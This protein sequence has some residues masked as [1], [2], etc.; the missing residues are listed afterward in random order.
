MYIFILAMMADTL[1][2]SS[3]PEEIHRSAELKRA[4]LNVFTQRQKLYCTSLEEDERLLRTE[5]SVRERMAVEVRLGEKRILRRA[6]ERVD[7]WVVSPP[8]KRVKTQ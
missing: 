7:A 6:S 4:V 8:A 2:A 1:D 3:I 5:L